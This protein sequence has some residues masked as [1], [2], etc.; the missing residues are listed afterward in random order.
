MADNVRNIIDEVFDD[1]DSDGEIIFS[2]FWI[3][4]LEEF[5]PVERSQD[6]SYDILNESLSV[7]GDRT[8]NR[9]TFIGKP[10]LCKEP[11]NCVL[12]LQI[13]EL[14]L[15]LWLLKYFGWNK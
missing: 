8:T 9:L 14:V 15:W 1:S 13:L 2:F 11:Y 6:N 10:G 5:G 12:P 7:P 3:F 4:D